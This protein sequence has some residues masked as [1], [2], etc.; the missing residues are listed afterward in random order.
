MVVAVG[1]P[2]LLR[3]IVGL[4]A[5]LLAIG[6]IVYLYSYFL[7]LAKNGAVIIIK[8]DEIP[9]LFLFIGC[10]LFFGTFAGFEI[11]RFAGSQ[12]QKKS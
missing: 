8:T 2:R 10:I 9:K 11:G 1:K 4:S 6:F 3:Y 12:N 5:L 7:E